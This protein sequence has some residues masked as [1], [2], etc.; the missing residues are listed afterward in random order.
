MA[1]FKVLVNDSEN[2]SNKILS[3]IGIAGE[4]LISGELCYLNT[5][6]KYYKSNANDYLKCSTELR[7]TKSSLIENEEGSFISQGSL[8]SSGLVVGVRYYVSTIEGSI[9]TL[10]P[11][12]PDIARYVG[13]ASS[14]TL[15]EFNPMDYISSSQINGLE[16]LRNYVHSQNLSSSEWIIDHPLNKYASISIIDSGNNIVYGDVEYI[17]LGRIKVNFSASFSGKAYLN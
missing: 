6:G 16:E 8:S 12:S 13:T 4:N 14:E 15:F 2:E 11:V 5:D 9:T 7:I 17:N 1:I 10:P 3:S